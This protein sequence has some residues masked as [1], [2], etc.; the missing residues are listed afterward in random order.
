MSE[1]RLSSWFVSPLAPVI[2]GMM[3]DVSGIID[4]APV[5]DMRRYVEAVQ[6]CCEY[7]INV[8]EGNAKPSTPR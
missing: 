2:E 8:A 5:D 4:N 7:L 1:S 6:V 3:E